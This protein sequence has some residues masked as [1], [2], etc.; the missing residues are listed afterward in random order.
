MV[1][2]GACSTMY[3]GKAAIAVSK[4]RLIGVEKAFRI[5]DCSHTRIWILPPIFPGEYSTVGNDAFWISLP[6]PEMHQVAAMAEP[7]IEE[8]RRVV[9]IKPEF[10]IHMRIE[11]TIGFP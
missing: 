10:Q 3:S 11:R 6:G 9:L 1:L 7:L 5:D 4:Y 8:S 2:D